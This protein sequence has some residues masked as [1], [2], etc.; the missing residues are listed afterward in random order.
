MFDAQTAV[1]SACFAAL[2]GSTDV[3]T[4]AD[5]WQNPPEDT[6]PTVK[7]LVVVGLVSLDASDVKGGGFEKATIEIR[8]YV[9][10][11]DATRLYAVNAAV[12]GAIEDQALTATGA[13]I[14]RPVFLGAEPGL[15]DDGKTYYDQLKFE[16]FVQAA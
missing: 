11:P 13:D 9:R 1:S 2:D 10:Q 4:L 14:G 15:L 16:M 5:V 3:T 8:T 7:G 6:Q 12:R